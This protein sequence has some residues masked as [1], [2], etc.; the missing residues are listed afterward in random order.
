MSNWPWPLPNTW[1]N[2]NGPVAFNRTVVLRY[3]I[4]LEQKQYAPSTLY[5]RLAAVP[6]I[7][8][9]VADSGLLDMTGRLSVYIREGKVSRIIWGVG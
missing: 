2:R 1:P 5:L 6:W 8:Y 9:E 3:R 4:H 7:G